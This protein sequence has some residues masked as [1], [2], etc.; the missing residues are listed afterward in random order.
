M[1]RAR[2]PG[3]AG[4]RAALRRA[5]RLVAR[6]SVVLAV[7]LFGGMAASPA[8]AQIGSAR[9]SSVVIEAQNGNLVSAINPDEPR[10]PASLTKM[11][12]LYLAFEALRDRRAALD[13][14]VPVSP[15]AAAMMPSKLGLLPGSRITVEQAVLALVTKSANDAA[16]AL[17]EFLGGGD[18]ERFAQMMTLRA[19]ALGMEHTVFRNASGLP[20]L[21][22]VTTARD[23]A[24]LARHLVQDFP[25]EYR[26]FSTPSFVYRGRLIPNH[27]HMLQSYPGAD[28]IK[29]GYIVASGFNL[30]TSAVRG[31]I[32]LIGVVLGAAHPG[33][34]DQHMAAL[35]DAGFEQLGVPIAPR[36]EP[37][38]EP[39]TL[40]GRIG[41]VASAQ[42][43]TLAGSG[44]ASGGRALVSHV[45]A[46]HLVAAPAKH[47]GAAAAPGRAA[48][49]P[50]GHPASAKDGATKDRATKDRATK[51]R[52]KARAAAS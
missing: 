6:V 22:Q 21:E 38:R 24:I 7:V 5:S 33:E 13:E 2:A 49:A 8:R 31:D 4:G 17:G 28:G 43:A 48:H 39:A 1:A 47:A 37:G 30:V 50:A 12:T 23:L 10:Y 42:A 11:M 20:D 9:Y 26:Y 36:G 52:A 34:R 35:L 44:L 3:E 18:E 14:L 15:H 16:A 32:R 25:L 41:L 19:R 45:A 27:D 40:A 51:D 29:T 46:H